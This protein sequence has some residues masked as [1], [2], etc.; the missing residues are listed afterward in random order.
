[1]NKLTIESDGK[2]TRVIMDGI[3]VSDKV[4][5]IRFQHTGGDMPLCDISMFGSTDLRSIST[6][7][8]CINGDESHG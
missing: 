4:T 3:D 7:R 5:S 6:V 8:K 2:R 1:M